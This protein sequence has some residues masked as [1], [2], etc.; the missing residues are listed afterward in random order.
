[1]EE[2]DVFRAADMC[3]DHPLLIGVVLVG[4]DI[5]R[6]DV[7]T[8]RDDR[9]IRGTGDRVHAFG[10]EEVAVLVGSASAPE[11]LSRDVVMRDG[12]RVRAGLRVAESVEGCVR[13]DGR[14]VLP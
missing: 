3:R 10:D 5:A 1:M 12:H 2:A 4:R 6:V 9:E 11:A 14:W 8:Q 7:A 13:G